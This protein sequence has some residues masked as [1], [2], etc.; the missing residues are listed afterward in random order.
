MAKIV[1]SS[2]SAKKRTDVWKMD[3]LHNKSAEY[4]DETG[5]I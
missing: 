5:Y 1:L 3:R 4:V 2:V